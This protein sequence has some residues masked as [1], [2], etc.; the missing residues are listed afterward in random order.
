MRTVEDSDE[1]RTV[2]MVHRGQLRRQLRTVTV[3]TVRTAVLYP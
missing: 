1:W 2:R 3:R